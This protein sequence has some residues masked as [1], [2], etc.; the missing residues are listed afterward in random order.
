MV[1]QS[2]KHAQN[3]Q[4]GQRTQTPSRPR[5]VS[6]DRLI[7]DLVELDFAYARECERIGRADAGSAA[8]NHVMNRLRELH[9]TRREPYLR[10]LTQAALL[11]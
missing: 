3:T 9:R 5:D 6:L 10:E 8:K 1:Q 2:P 7:T 11:N 4:T